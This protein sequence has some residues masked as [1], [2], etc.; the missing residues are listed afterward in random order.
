MSM[1]VLVA[2][3]ELHVPSAQSLKAKRSVVTSIVR[4]LDQL[5]GVGAAEVDHQDLWQRTTIGVSAVGS[6]PAHIESVMDQV[7]R[8]IWSRTEVEVLDIERSWWEGA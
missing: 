7:E 3:I 4:N 2:E 8:Y 6:S 1:H 5:H